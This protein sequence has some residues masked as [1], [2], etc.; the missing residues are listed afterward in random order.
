MLLGHRPCTFVVR[1]SLNWMNMGIQRP[2]LSGEKRTLLWCKRPKSMGK[3]CWHSRT[4][5][6]LRSNSCSIVIVIFRSRSP[7]PNMGWNSKDAWTSRRMAADKTDGL[8]SVSGQSI[9]EERGSYIGIGP[10]HSTTSWFTDEG[11][12]SVLHSRSL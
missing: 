6:T 11:L 1:Q 10:V 3:T 5:V 4:P 2:H 12:F 8:Q 9:S 7:E